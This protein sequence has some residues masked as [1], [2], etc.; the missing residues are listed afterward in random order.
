ME[1]Y[2]SELMMTLPGNRLDYYQTSDVSKM[3]SS[4]YNVTNEIV[5]TLGFYPL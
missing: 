5:E 1:T 3:R 2:A 4:I